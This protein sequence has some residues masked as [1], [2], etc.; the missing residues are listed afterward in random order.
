MSDEHP[1]VAAFLHA[2]TTGQPINGPNHGEFMAHEKAQ[3]TKL[4]ALWQKTATFLTGEIEIGGVK[5]RIKVSKVR[6]K[7]DNPKRPDW[8]I[9]LDDWKKP[10]EKPQY[11]PDGNE[12]PSPMSD[13]DIPF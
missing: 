2:I 9:A 8:T 5:T 1:R 11:V 13:S 4:G 12:P 6:D 10:E 3:D 7:G